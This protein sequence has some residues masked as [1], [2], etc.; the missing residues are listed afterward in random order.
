MQKKLN[1]YEAEI[2]RLKNSGQLNIDMR[3]LA[4]QCE[5]LRQDTIHLLLKGSSKYL[6]N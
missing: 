6:L 1:E 5:G 2:Y 3:T 4:D